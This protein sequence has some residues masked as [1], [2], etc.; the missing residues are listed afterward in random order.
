MSKKP[1]SGSRQARALKGTK[2]SR[3]SPRK[4]KHPGVVG[5]QQQ[6]P[7]ASRGLSAANVAVAPRQASRTPPFSSSAMD[8]RR[9]LSCGARQR[10]TSHHID[11]L[12]PAPMHFDPTHACEGLVS[13]LR[14]KLDPSPDL[15]ARL[16]SME[17]KL[18]RECGESLSADAEGPV[19]FSHKVLA[20]CEPE[21][22]I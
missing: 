20:A 16:R 2:R 14:A 6:R 1:P 5:A 21:P 19:G 22:S 11:A 7:A 15:L 17:L 9:G 3:S 18:E 4:A 8:P 13:D 12:G 10:S